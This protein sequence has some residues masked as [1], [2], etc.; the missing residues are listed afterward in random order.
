MIELTKEGQLVKGDKI[1]I[2]GKSPKDSQKT[3]VKEIVINGKGGEEVIIN[4]KQN[5]Y[6][7][8]A[9]FLR[10]ESRADKVFIEQSR[11]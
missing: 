10:G 5:K 7:I 6:F 8:T 11:G 4:K 1:T 2:I 9:M 3:T